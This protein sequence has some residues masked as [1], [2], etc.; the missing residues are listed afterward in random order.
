MNINSP[1]LP[2]QAKALLDGQEKVSTYESTGGAVTAQF[3]KHNLSLIPPIPSGSIIHDN[4]CGSGTAARAI[5]TLPN[6]PSDLKIHAT[7]TDQLFLDALQSDVNKNGWNVEVKN[8]KSE[9]LAFE[10]SYF[11]YSITNIGIFFFTAAG[12]DGARE[13]YR[14]LKPGG[15]AVVNCWQHVTWFAP[16]KSVHDVTRPNQPYPAPPI[17]WSDGKQIQKVMAEAGFSKEKT[18]VERSDA[19]ARM[20]AGELR[21]WAEKTWAYLGGIGTWREGD[22]AR[23]DEAIDK[24]VEV[25]RS[26]DGTKIVKGDDGEEIVEMRAG[27]WVVIAEK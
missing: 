7:D 2:K 18:R 11:D 23:W 16:L 27:Q 12:V 14:T 26:A 6:G 22:E 17:G 8:M 25:L 24:L 19:W 21:A 1:Q 13:I 20:K 3:A 10:D 15:I 9:E 5:L 4:A